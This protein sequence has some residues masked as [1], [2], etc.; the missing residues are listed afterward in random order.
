MDFMEEDF[1]SVGI[2]E[3]HPLQVRALMEFIGLSLSIAAANKNPHALED[4]KHC[5][6]DLIHMLG[7]NGIKVETRH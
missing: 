3:M 1:N 5:A 7:G 2:K 6:D 4:V